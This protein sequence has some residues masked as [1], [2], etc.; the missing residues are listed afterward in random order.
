MILK[1]VI[2]AAHLLERVIN[3]L[4]HVA[5]FFGTKHQSNEVWRM[6]LFAVLGLLLVEIFVAN[7]TFA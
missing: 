6:L 1:G 7:R 4:I 5:G 2:G 3:V